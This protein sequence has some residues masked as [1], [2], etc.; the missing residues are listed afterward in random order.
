MG[1]L[2]DQDRT[3]GVTGETLMRALRRYLVTQLS[4]PRC[5]VTMKPTHFIATV[6]WPSVV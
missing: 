5:S 6:S 2:A 1:E 3:E 4:A